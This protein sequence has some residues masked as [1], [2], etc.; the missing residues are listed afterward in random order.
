[1]S[2]YIMEGKIDRIGP[3][4]N[5]NPQYYNR[6]LVIS[7]VVEGREQFVCFQFSESLQNRG[8]LLY[9]LDDY[10]VGET[11]EVQFVV[12]GGYSRNSGKNWVMLNAIAIN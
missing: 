5:T 1:M 2:E 4:T 11:V 10:N 8:T 6:E 9:K 3:E 7:T 12:K